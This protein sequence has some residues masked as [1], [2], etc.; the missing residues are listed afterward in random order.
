M[1]SKKENGFENNCK[2]LA[3]ILCKIPFAVKFERMNEFERGRATRS[4][5]V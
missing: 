2:I 5:R 4:V 3:A 1:F